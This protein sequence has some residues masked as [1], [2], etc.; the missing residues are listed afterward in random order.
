MGSFFVVRTLKNNVEKTDERVSSVK[1]INEKVT[2]IL[3]G[4]WNTCIGIAK[5]INNNL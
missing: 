2:V 5:Y 4:K 3:S 1:K